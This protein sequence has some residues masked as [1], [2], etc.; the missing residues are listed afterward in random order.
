MNKS[1]IDFCHRYVLFLFYFCLNTKKNT[2]II[3]RNITYS[4]DRERKKQNK[5]QRGEEKER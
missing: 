5:T 2:I 1:Q 3:I 4:T